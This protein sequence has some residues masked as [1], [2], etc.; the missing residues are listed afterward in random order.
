MFRSVASA[1]IKTTGMIGGLRMPRCLLGVFAIIAVLCVAGCGGKKETEV[2]GQVKPQPTQTSPIK[3]R[4]GYRASLPADVGP[5]WAYEAGALKDAGFDVAVKGFGPPHML[6]QALRSGEIDVVTVM[7]LEPVL[8]DIRTAKANYR[9]YCLQCFSATM[10]FDAV[11]V[12]AP[13]TGTTA[14][15][16]GLTGALGVIPSR[17]N[18]LI[19]EA[20]V[21]GAGANLAVRPFNPQNP[22]MSLEGGDFS[23]VHVLGAD[24]A[25]ARAAPSKYAV[26]EAC[27]ASKRAFDGHDVPAGAGLISEAWILAHPD[28]VQELID[29]MLVWSQKTRDNPADPQLQALLQK[30][31]YGSL[32]A[33][34]AALLTYAP[35]LTYRE[36]KSE[37]LAPLIT[38]LQSR[39]VELPST[40]SVLE[41]LV[42]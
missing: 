33:E 3:V 14:S 1:G 19:G 39:S 30:V 40:E 24:V 20:I 15:W 23:A 5:L 25:R 7:P 12:K 32:S 29:M 10:P 38:F 6:L 4:I 36:V 9:I 16:E 21:T 8:E 11:V 2:Q 37:H 31:Q 41:K 26:I 27:A 28:G 34:E 42:R 35:L 22:L 13:A 17:Q 18:T